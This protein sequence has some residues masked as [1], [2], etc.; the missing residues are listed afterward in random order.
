MEEQWIYI[1]KHISKVKNSMKHMNFCRRQFMACTCL[2]MMPKSESQTDV[3]GRLTMLAFVLEQMHHCTYLGAVIHLFW[4]HCCTPAFSVVLGTGFMRRAILATILSLPFKMAPWELELNC[5]LGAVWLSWKVTFSSVPRTA[6][7]P[8]LDLV[9][10]L[11][12]VG[13]G[14]NNRLRLRAFWP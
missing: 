14:S 8:V 12:I 3:R 7:Y 1:M 6:T 4:W 2:V 10:S 11:R 5:A 13:L 9:R